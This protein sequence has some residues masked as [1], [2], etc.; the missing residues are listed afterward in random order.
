MAN[1]KE[2]RVTTIDGKNAA[3]SV[4]YEDGTTRVA[5]DRISL[6]SPLDPAATRVQVANQLRAFGIDLSDIAAAQ[7]IIEWLGT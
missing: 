1:V 6:L 2:V 7:I 5:I 4:E 3:V